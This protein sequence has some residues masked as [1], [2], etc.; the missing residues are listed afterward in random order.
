MA[1]PVPPG[2]PR[3]GS[4]PPPPNYVPNYRPNSDGLADNFNNLNLNRP[5]MTSN[6]VARPPPFGQQP[7]FPSSGPGIHASQPPFSR[8]GPPLPSGFSLTRKTLL[9]LWEFC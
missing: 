1:A 8:P 2:A 5:P 7:P 9:H 4:Q 3:P 6:P